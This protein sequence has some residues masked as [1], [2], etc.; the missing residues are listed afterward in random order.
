MKTGNTT[1]VTVALGGLRVSLNRGT[2]LQVHETKTGFLTVVFL[3]CMRKQWSK[4]RDEARL[5]L[6]TSDYSWFTRWTCVLGKLGIFPP[7]PAAE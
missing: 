4:L 5:T 7:P 1:I 3:L 2:S 6:T